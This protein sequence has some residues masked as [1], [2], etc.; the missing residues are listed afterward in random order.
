M[1]R[2]TL[3]YSR[4]PTEQRHPASRELDRLSTLSLLRLMHREDA[5]A[6]RAVG[7]QLRAVA[8]AIDAIVRA[9]RRGGRLVFVGAGTSGRLGVVEAAECPP[10]FHTAP[11][12]VQALI[13][14]GRVAV[15]RS[16]EGAEDDRRAARAAIRRRVRRGDVVVGIAASGVTPYVAEALRVAGRLGAITIL[17]SCHPRPM[18]R[19]A[20]RITPAVGPEVLTGS[21]RLKAGTATKL[22][23][24]MLTLGA[25]VRLGKTYGNLMVDVRP[26]S[27]KLRARAIG[28]LRTLTGCSQAA[29][30][31]LLR[32][33]RGRVKIAVL[34]ARDGITPAAAARRL[35]DAGD[36][37]RLALFGDSH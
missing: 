6:V 18:M 5:R 20:I 22:V 15:F 30:S 16:R 37:L 26:T 14:G 36:S 24:N 17:L 2:A 1:P 4:L 7:R 27:R 34:L 23:L 11:S 12:T 35:S 29:A 33:A 31:Q 19:A 21:T 13:A 10:T 32:R 28:L 8:R 3:R 25:M 9:L